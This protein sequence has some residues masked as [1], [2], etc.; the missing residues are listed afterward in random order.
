MSFK[1]ICYIFGVLWYMYS[2]GLF[3]FMEVIMVL[4]H[5][6]EHE[7]MDVLHHGLIFG[8]G[9]CAGLAGVAWLVAKYTK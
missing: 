2:V 6:V 7:I 8:L 4:L 1:L 3:F 5:T 9:L